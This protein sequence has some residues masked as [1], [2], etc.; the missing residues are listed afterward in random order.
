MEKTKKTIGSIQPTIAVCGTQ[1]K[2][3]FDLDTPSKM[4]ETGLGN[5]ETRV[6]NFGDKSALLEKHSITGYGSNKYYQGKYSGRLNIPCPFC[7]GHNLIKGST[8]F[9]YGTKIKV[10]Q[11]RC[12][13]CKKCFTD[14]PYWNMHTPPY[15]LDFFI[16]LIQTGQIYT[17]THRETSS[18]IKEKF[19]FSVGSSTISGWL[20]KYNQGKIYRN[21]IPNSKLNKLSK[22]NIKYIPKKLNRI[23]IKCKHCGHS[24][25]N[26]DG[27]RY[28][29]KGINQKYSCMSCH[30][31]FSYDLTYER[32]KKFIVN[33]YL[34]GKSLRETS[35]E[36]QKKF[37]R[38]I[39]HATVLRRLKK[40]GLLEKKFRVVI[41]TQKVNGKL[42]QVKR[43]FGEERMTR[44]LHFLM[45]F[46]KK[47]VKAKIIREAYQLT[48][49]CKIKN[50][51][52]IKSGLIG[53]RGNGFYYV[54]LNDNG[55]TNF[56]KSSAD[57]F[58]YQES[59]I[60][61]KQNPHDIP[62]ITQESYVKQ[63]AD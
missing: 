37:Y 23:I 39:H 63:K 58:P 11:Y 40:E 2:E 14:S 5:G 16:D 38:K 30:K 31:R 46:N 53:M 20:K 62:K 21:R 12:L 59:L 4:E 60:A 54:N 32:E 42:M 50:C 9:N 10:K 29:K 1:N 49:M 27:L 15:I 33:C 28:T 41:S 17:N 48:P 56:T 7:L 24:F 8:R 6:S 22:P 52:L 13:D 45:P 36:F 35:S 57:D 18:L 26:K 25:A 55:G 44:A 61:D 19:N 43:I 34:M 47:I 3:A 51:K